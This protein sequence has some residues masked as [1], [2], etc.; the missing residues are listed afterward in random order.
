MR[1]SETPRGPEV[2]ESVPEEPKREGKE[3]VRET[4]SGLR[5]ERASREAASRVEA[6]AEAERIRESLAPA[7]VAGPEAALS[8]DFADASRDSLGRIELGVEEERDVT[9]KVATHKRRSRFTPPSLVAG[10][11]TAT[12][13]DSKAAN[14]STRTAIVE[15]EDGRK[16]FAVYNYPTS[17]IHRGLDTVSKRLAGLKMRKAPSREWKRV[18]EARSTIPTFQY[19]DPDVVLMPYIPNVNAHDLFARNKEIKDFGPCP[20]AGDAGLDE[21]LEIGERIVEELAAVHESGRNWGETILPNIIV[22]EEKRPIIVDPETTYDADVPDAEQRARDLRD[23]LM[24][25]AGALRTSEGV[26][27]FRPV[28]SR[29]VGAYKDPEVIQALKSLAAEKPSILQKIMRA[30]YETARLGIKPDDYQKVMDAVL[31]VA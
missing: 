13:Y 31:E 11:K 28:V 6:L 20:W 29:L 26:E 27:D 2:R 10:A 17:W 21:K 12:E 5:R 4:P 18:F 16:A 1:N 9:G 7:E 14:F 19:D 22:T 25:I 30:A 23:I 8:G 15:L 3:P 24:S